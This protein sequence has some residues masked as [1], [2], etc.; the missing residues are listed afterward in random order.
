M[1]WGGRGSRRA[2]FVRVEVSWAASRR[3]YKNLIRDAVMKKLH[4]ADV[5]MTEDRLNHSV[6][7]WS[8]PRVTLSYAYSLCTKVL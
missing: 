8:L 7:I 4:F 2:V 3:H 6:G 5:T 1:E